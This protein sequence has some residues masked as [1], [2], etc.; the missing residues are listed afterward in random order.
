MLEESLFLIVSHAL[1]IGVFMFSKRLLIGVGLVSFLLIS[2]GT[3]KKVPNQEENFGDGEEISTKNEIL[4][5]KFLLIPQ[6]NNAYAQAYSWRTEKEERAMVSLKNSDIDFI[7]Y[8]NV[9][10]YIFQVVEKIKKESVDDFQKVK[11]LHDIVALTVRYDAQG[12]LTGNIPSQDYAS[13]LKRGT[14]VCEGFS[15]TVKKFCD[16]LGISCRVVHGYARGVGTKAGNENSVF[17][18]NHAWNIVKINGKELTG[19]WVDRA[20]VFQSYSLFPWMSALENV[21][22]A[23]YETSKKRTQVSKKQAHETAR[24][25]LHKVELDGFENKLPGELSGGMQQRVAIARAM[26]CNPDILLMDEPF[27]A[28]DAKIREN[29]QNLLLSLWRNDEQKKTIIFVTHDLNEAELLA[30]RIVFMIPKQIQAVIEDTLPRPRNY[31]HIQE[32]EAFK[33]LYQKLVKYFYSETLQLSD[34]EGVNL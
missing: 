12:F 27:G 10:S 22:F 19:P 5:K 13:V 30:D 20:V 26:A 18:S 9:E 15:N 8:T 21:A 4:E 31:P 23:V 1:R 2:C 7:R 25:F 3:T 24:I 6:N 32:S 14:A 29:L 11:M 28:L 34:G 16:E 17:Q 33:K